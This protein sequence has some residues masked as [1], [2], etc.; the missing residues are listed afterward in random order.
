MSTSRER[1]LEV[2]QRV[3]AKDERYT[4]GIKETVL[5]GTPFAHK[6][7]NNAEWW[8]WFTAWL[9]ENPWRLPWLP[10]MENGPEMLTKYIRLGGFT[11]PEE[12]Y[13]RLEAFMADFV[14][15]QKA[16][17]QQAASMAVAPPAVPVG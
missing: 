17:A 9:A 6:Q 13:A 15:G 12:G 5:E 4:E 8:T 2:M 1:E 16:K 14:A 10:V 7:L 3:I 11:S